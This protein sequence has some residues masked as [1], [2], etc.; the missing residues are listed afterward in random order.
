MPF[1]DYRCDDCNEIS[2]EFH[3][4]NTS[5]DDC[6]HCESPHYH[7]TFATPTQGFVRG[8]WMDERFLYDGEASYNPKKYG[9]DWG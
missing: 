7:K 8:S 9:Q 4:M 6:P 3:S 1:Y 2:E 5:A